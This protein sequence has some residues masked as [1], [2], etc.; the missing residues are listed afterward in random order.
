MSR[1]LE[2]PA[3]FVWPFNGGHLALRMRHAARNSLW[4]DIMCSHD[5]AA[6]NAHLV[7]SEISAFRKV[8]AGSPIHRFIVYQ[9]LIGCANTGQKITYAVAARL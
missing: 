6:S 7:D 3:F 8:W 4:G 1:P 2:R 9:S 5:G